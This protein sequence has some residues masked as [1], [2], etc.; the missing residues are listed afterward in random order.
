LKRRFGV[1]GSFGLVAV[2]V[3]SLFPG[4]AYGLAGAHTYT[5]GT[6]GDV[7]LGGDYIELGISKR[8]SFGTTSGQALPSGFYGTASRTNVGMSS[9]AAGFG[10]SP[11]TRIDYFLPGT[12][13]ERWV[14]GYKIGGTA[15]TGSN[16]LLMGTNSISDNTV[17]DQ[18]SGTQLM[19]TS[20]GTFNSKLDITQVISFNAGDKFFKNEVTLKNIDSA[21]LDSVRYMRTFDPD[22]T[23]DKGGQSQT[24]NQILYTFAAG[25]GKAVVMADTSHNNSD[26][27]YVANGSRSPILF[28]SNDSRARVSS[29]GFSNSDPYAA[30]AYDSA[31]AK[32]TAY[33]GDNAIT[34]TF[35]VG[36]LAAGASQK[37][38]YYTSLDNR[39]FDEVLEDIE[40]DV[41]ESTDDGDNVS[42]AVEDGAPNSGDGNGDGTAD[43]TQQNVTSLRNPIA[44]DEAYQT[45]ATTGCTG[46]TSVT[47][48]PLNMYGDDGSYVYPVGLTS[49]SLSCTIP[50]DT[51]N[52]TIYYDKAYDTSNW[53]ARKFVNN[54][55][56]DIPGAVLGTATVGGQSVTTLSYT[57]TDG[58]ELD[59]DGSVNGTI[60]D[61]AGPSVLASEASA[62]MLAETGSNSGLYSVLSIILIFAALATRFTPLARRDS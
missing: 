55:F 57:I 15:S 2:L 39:D 16:S 17:T 38:I 18:S 32:G 37:V 51:A 47:V 42:K 9:N 52:V 5:N 41:E 45:L 53:K 7:F 48:N 59:A 40:D 43:S 3:L 22:N 19:A 30:S 26:P 27:V 54:T 21:P 25:D 61:P 60:V 34:I 31:S 29:Y 44:G 4:T 14:V 35:D 28:Y 8:G 58:G 33:T 56:I 6:T 12:P 62:P 1:V 50:G 49:F 20:H 13:E 36:T 11:D 23:V 46:L 10:N 24:R